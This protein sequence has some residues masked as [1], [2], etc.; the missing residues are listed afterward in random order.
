LRRRGVLDLSVFVACFAAA[1][2][3]SSLFDHGS[4]GWRA[5]VYVALLM[6]PAFVLHRLPA[7]KCPA[8]KTALEHVSHLDDMGRELSATCCPSCDV[9]VD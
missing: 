4:L 3:L 9:E 7:Q 1:L 2:G 8:C 6:L 5:F